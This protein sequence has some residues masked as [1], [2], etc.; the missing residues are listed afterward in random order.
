MALHRTLS[1]RLRKCLR[2]SG[3]VWLLAWQP[4]YFVG[5]SKTG[6]ANGCLAEAAEAGAGCKIPYLATPYV[7]KKQDGVLQ[8]Q[9]CS[10]LCSKLNCRK[11]RL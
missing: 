8:A 9:G 5:G 10:M 2:G 7:W 4:K 11:L 6:T 1:Q 3:Q